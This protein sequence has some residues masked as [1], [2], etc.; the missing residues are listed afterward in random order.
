MA[1]FIQ[2]YNDFNNKDSLELVYSSWAGTT[3]FYA[4][5]PLENIPIGM[6]LKM[7]H[8]LLT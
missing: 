7:L 8:E 3:C 6:T 2:L 4:Q 5:N 1:E